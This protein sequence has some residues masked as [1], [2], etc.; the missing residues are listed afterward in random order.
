V[1]GEGVVNWS[2]GDTSED[3]ISDNIIG[4]PLLLWKYPVLLMVT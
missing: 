3:D 4:K 2:Q 1:G